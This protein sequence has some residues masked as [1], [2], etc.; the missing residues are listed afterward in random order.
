MINLNFL[1]GLF[2]SVAMIGCTEATSNG[3]A[4]A[5]VVAD[6]KSNLTIT[7]TIENAANQTIYF[8]QF[9]GNSDIDSTVIGDNGAFKLGANIDKVDFYKLFL[10]QQRLII[11]P[12]NPSDKKLKLT[13][14]A[15]NMMGTYTVSG[16]QDAELMHS[17][18][19]TRADFETEK[20]DMLNK[21]QSLQGKEKQVEV[22]KYQN[23]IKKLNE[24][25][26]QMAMDNSSSPAALSIVS[27]L[28]PNVY[29]D[30]YDKVMADLRGVIPHSKSY[31]GMQKELAKLKDQQ[32]KAQFA[33]NM[34]G[35]EAPDLEF[36]TPD[37]DMV[38]L[39]SLRGKYVLIDFWA[40]WCGP[41]RKENPNVVK[42]YDMY[43]DQGFEILGVSLDKDK[44]KWVK[45]IETDQLTWPQISDLGGWQSQ[46]ASAYGV[47]SIPFTVL[48]D[49]EGKVMATKLRGP[50]LEAKLAEIFGS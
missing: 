8:Q 32:K 33:Q 18:W 6:A 38:S 45:A 27:N 46:A 23:S 4:E 29:M 40:S 16:S 26:K 43:K 35:Q 21:I 47:R 49:K 14:D 41:C 10:D 44:A 50:A 31:V 39:S 7:G 25:F 17:F 13:A 48:V 19:K 42:V 12:L 24:S 9:D 30:V 1:L 5:G 3:A 36:P 15:T 37:G 20:N 22:A 11:L 34:V 28:D 2:L